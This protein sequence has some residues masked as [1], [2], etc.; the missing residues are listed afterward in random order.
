MNRATPSQRVAAFALDWLVWTYVLAAVVYFFRRPLAQAPWVA[1]GREW[2][3]SALYVLSLALGFELAGLTGS[4]GRTLGHRFAGLYVDYHG[5]G[6]GLLRFLAWNVGLVPAGLGSWSMLRD[7]DGLAW[8]DRLTGARV[9]SARGGG[10]FAPPAG[11]PWYLTLAGLLSAWVAVETLIL[12]W[13]VTEVDL[14]RLFTQAGKIGNVTRFL[15]R[16]N[17][18]AAPRVID[19][20]IETVFLALMS[21]AFA[22]PAA[23]V[24]GFLAARNLMLPLRVRLDALIGAVLGGA[25][26]AWLGA[27]V[28]SFL[29]LVGIVSAAWAGAGGLSLAGGLL[30]LTLGAVFGA[31][32]VR[33]CIPRLGPIAGRAVLALFAAAIGVGVMRVTIDVAVT[34]ALGSFWGEFYELFPLPSLALLAA[35]GLLFGGWTARRGRSPTEPFP[36]GPVIYYGMRT[37]LNLV[38]SVEP[39]IWA[40]VFV[41]WVRVGPFPGMLALTVHSIASL[42]KLYSEQ[43]EN[44]DQGPVEAVQATGANGLQTVAY[45]V[46]PQVVPSYIAFTLYRWDINVRMSTIIGM[47]G[48]GGIGQRLQQAMQLSQWREA[49]LVILLIVVVVMALDFLSAKV[50]EGI[51]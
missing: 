33:R 21:T 27:S 11:L 26:G 18:T 32:L 3:A 37:I 17:W 31:R 36:L 29:A 1:L 16:P 50:R 24:L 35:G 19:A 22:I 49:G 46:I 28:W 7:R 44:I 12:G 4:L 42:A 15:V 14:Y 51:K 13:Q 41:V 6:K 23:F 40:I 30:G 2:D 47:V 34:V 38:R 5:L 48:G 8:H 10:T 20:M 39:L 45:A 25:A 43:V 9:W